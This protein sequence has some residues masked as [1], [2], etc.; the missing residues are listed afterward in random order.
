MSWLTDPKNITRILAQRVAQGFKPNSVRRS[1][2]RATSDLLAHELGKSRK[3]AIPVD[4]IKPKDRDPRDVV[5][6]PDQIEAVLD[7]C[8]EEFRLFVAS[9]LLTGVDQGPL[10]RLRVSHFDETGGRLHV[11]D[12]KS[13]A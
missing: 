13:E 7:S 12:T 11:P 6:N 3:S 2:Y 1:L 9:A 4:V 10:L 8:D 5:L